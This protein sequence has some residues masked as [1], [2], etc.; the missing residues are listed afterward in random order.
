MPRV[1]A[2]IVRTSAS[3]P[4]IAEVEIDQHY[5]RPALLLTE[6]LN[7]RNY[8]FEPCCAMRHRPGC[9]QKMHEVLTSYAW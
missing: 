9:V 3:F 7:G 8:R 6:S 1:S 4:H 5:M 2:V